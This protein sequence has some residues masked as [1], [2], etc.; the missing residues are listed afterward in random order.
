M[1]G[2][3]QKPSVGLVPARE[4]ESIVSKE[5]AQTKSQSPP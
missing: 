5:P 4:R 3:T 1:P 2:S